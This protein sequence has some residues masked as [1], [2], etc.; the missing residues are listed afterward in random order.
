M[1]M[2]NKRI[3]QLSAERLTLTS[4]DYV[5]VDDENN[6]SAKYRLDRLKE[7]DTTLS[8]SGKAADA[9][10][11]GQAI[12][13]EA[14][15]RDN[16]DNALGEDISDL[17]SA[18]P[19]KA[20][21]TEFYAE[22]KNYYDK[23]QLALNTWIPSGNGHESTYNSWSSTGYIPIDGHTSFSFLVGGTNGVY[24]EKSGIYG[25][26][27]DATKT[28]VSGITGTLADATIPANAKYF[29][30]SHETRYFIKDGNNANPFS[31]II[32]P[33]EW[34][35]APIYI[36]SYVPYGHTLAEGIDDITNAINYNA[37]RSVPSWTL[38]EV[39]E[40]VQKVRNLQG[41]NTLSFAFLTDMHNASNLNIRAANHHAI[42]S[43]QSIE[44]QIPLDY[45][46]F[47][48]DYLSNSTSTTIAECEEQLQDLM[49]YI[50]EVQSPMFMLRGNHDSNH[51]NSSAPFTAT[52]FY[53]DTDKF[54]ENSNIVMYSDELERSF[55]YV[56]LE[57][58]KVRM[59]FCNMT[60]VQDNASGFGLGWEQMDWFGHI[61]LDFSDKADK[62]KWGAIVFSHSYF[63]A[64]SITDG[65]LSL[66]PQMHRMLVA[67]KNGTRYEYN[68]DHIFDYTQQGAMEVI[69]AVVGHWHADRSAVVD[70]IQVIATMQTAGGGDEPAD[71]GTTYAKVWGTADETAYDIFTINRDTKT[72]NTTRFG[73]GVDR[74]WT[75]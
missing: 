48:G 51:F 8:V 18:F 41:G 62:D 15:A 4:G 21:N 52:M 22:N 53:R 38:E 58:L 42:Q 36:A 37:L 11:T 40:V 73:V 20:D 39:G 26:F 10:A 45:V 27:Y 66:A 54:F 60:D 6:G 19:V 68:A 14:E 72:I 2:E 46:V 33:T 55:G 69:C 23:M 70:G 63:E 17:K 50:N 71:G 5:M 59:I 12:S 24:S 35:T 57:N 13:D 61:A 65:G 31:M 34:N 75:Y 16:A 28:Y 1:A 9:A 3:T 56:D 29:R 30:I 67:F 49:K 43:L 47:G 44:K 7:T 64:S 74:S 32:D 25:A